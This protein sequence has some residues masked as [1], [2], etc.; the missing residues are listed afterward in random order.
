MFITV[1]ELQEH[2]VR[3]DETFP[4]GHIDYLTEGVSQ[5][6]ALKVQ[7]RANLLAD[8]IEIRG[9]LATSLE[10]VC[11]RCLDPLRHAVSVNFDL[12]YR[13]ISTMKR[14]DEVRVPAGEENIGFYH[15][16]GLL[17]ED[18]AKEQVLLSLPIR[19]VCGP[20]CRGLCPGCGRNLNREACVCPARVDPRL[21][22]LLK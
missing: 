21:Q 15:G 6:E 10:L 2:P 18:V 9:Q 20:D 4:P 22:N 19:S 5:V 14:A 8:E 12:V 1:E 16:G 13:P 3:F 11:A 17:L 7:G